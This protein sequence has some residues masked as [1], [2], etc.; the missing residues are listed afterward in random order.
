[1]FLLTISD[2]IISVVNSA[3][4]WGITVMIAFTAAVMAV[5][6]LAYLFNR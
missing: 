6:L 5:S 3:Y 4:S 1:M 2:D